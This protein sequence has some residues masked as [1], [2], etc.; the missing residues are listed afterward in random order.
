MPFQPV[1]R[2]NHHHHGRGKPVVFHH[3]LTIALH[4]RSL[5]V[6]QGYPHLLAYHQV[7]CKLAPVPLHLG[8]FY[9]NLN[10]LITGLYHPCQYAAEV[11]QF[12]EHLQH[13]QM[14]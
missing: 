9:H 3:V 5:L 8:G 6:I 2:I 10:R 4:R 14:Q 12:Y 7:V 11:S 13:D 1:L